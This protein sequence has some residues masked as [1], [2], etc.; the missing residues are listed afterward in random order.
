LC[1]PNAW[2]GARAYLE[3]VKSKLFVNVDDADQSWIADDMLCALGA[4][5]VVA[6]ERERQIGQAQRDRVLG[7]IKVVPVGGLL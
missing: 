4:D 1:G 3:H 6:L 7:M 2:E 5:A